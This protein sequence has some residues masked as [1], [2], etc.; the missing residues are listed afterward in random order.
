MRKSAID[1]QVK[2]LVQG[3]GFRPFIYR[4]AGEHQLAGWVKNTNQGVDIR[5]SGPQ[6]SLNSFL[7]DLKSKCPLA[8][9]IEEI[10]VDEALPSE[11]DG[12]QI[13]DSQS[14]SKEVT[15]VSPDLAVCD[16]CIADMKT[17]KHRADYPFINCT[18]CGPRFSIIQTIP[19]DRVNT[20]MSAFRMCE[21]CASEYESIADRRFHAQPVACNHCGPQ[22][23]L[24]NDQVLHDLPQILI[25][26]AKFLDNGGIV[27]VKG[28][29]GYFLAC[30]AF[31]ELAV[32]KLRSSKRRYGKPFAVMFRDL[33]GLEDFAFVTESERALI[34][35]QRRPIVILKAKRSV[36]TSVDMGFNTIGVMLPYMPLHYLLFEKL[37]TNAIV[38]TS[39]NLS[40]EPIV[41]S[42]EEA[43]SKLFPISDA[44][45][46]YNRDIHNRVDDSVLMI[47]NEK[48][49][50]VRR[51]RGFVPSPIHLSMKAE[52]ILAAGAELVNCFAIGKDRDAIMS[53]HIGDLK[54][55]ETLDFYEESIERFSQLFSFQPELIVCDKHPDYLSSVYARK[56]GLQC[57]SVQHHYAHIASC[58]AEE[59][60]DEHVIGVSFD[61]TGYGDD[62]NIWG[63][64]FLIADL[65]DFERAE[66][67][68]YMPMPGGDQAVKNPW[69]MA[70]SFLYNHFGDTVADMDLPFI[71]RRNRA[72]VELLIQS[73]QKDINCPRSSSMGRLFDGVAAICGLCD[74]TTFHAEA[75]MRLESIIDTTVEANYDIEYSRGAIS[76]EPLF[77]A[78]IRDMNAHVDVGM[79]SAKFH[80]AIVMLTQR[81]VSALSEEYGIRKVIL[82]GGTFQNRFILQNLEQRLSKAN[83]EV[84]SNTK[85]PV[86]DG[87]IALGQLIIAAKRREQSCV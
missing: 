62:G 87:G 33:E 2:G 22:Y 31:D 11:L 46:E 63:G 30:N 7:D 49:R 42:D 68:P 25:E 4:L 73:I 69:R 50:F 10:I 71:G 52:G 57:I 82:S 43:R 39:G 37:T 81:V 26:T 70:I 72:E 35:S 28:M 53:Q 44:V 14:L 45:L 1:I 13:L 23:I 15:R 56:S 66:H 3:V 40:E 84:Y 54:N 74:E 47:V 27:T 8:A 21:Q 48:R 64:E 60:I 80:N 85:V 41:I 17:Q 65:L 5:I 19:Y 34:T 20:T 32:Q 16:M 51:S 9:D 12:F 38:L 79:I 29:G 6:S 76:F 24:Y 67:L 58:M 86:N 18:Y 59:G 83:F 55:A 77:N 75:P 36:A 61:G 78:L